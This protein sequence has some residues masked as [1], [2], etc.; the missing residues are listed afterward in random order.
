M[1]ILTPMSSTI[2]LSNPTGP[3]ELLT[4]FAIAAAAITEIIFSNLIFFCWFDRKKKK[5]IV[6]K[7]KNFKKT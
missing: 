6:Q 1:Y 4:T 3:K 2:I 7:I 5:K